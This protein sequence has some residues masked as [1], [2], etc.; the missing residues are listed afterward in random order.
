MYTPRFTVNVGGGRLQRGVLELCRDQVCG[1][2]R[3]DDWWICRDT[4]SIPAAHRHRSGGYHIPKSA[5]LWWTSWSLRKSAAGGGGLPIGYAS[6]LHAVP[7][8]HHT[9]PPP[10]EARFSSPFSIS[11]AV[12]PSCEH[13]RVGS[14]GGVA[15]A[16]QGSS[17]RWAQNC[18]VLPPRVHL[19]AP[20]GS[21]HARKRQAQNVKAPPPPPP[22]PS[23]HTHI[24]TAATRDG[25]HEHPGCRCL[26][27][28]QVLST[29]DRQLLILPILQITNRYAAAERD[30]PN[31][32]R[33]QAEIQS[34]PQVPA[35]RF[36]S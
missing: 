20:M 4:T 30:S 2:V 29:P 18:S 6:H 14:P 27:I 8:Q 16:L 9:A 1:H 12:F 10:N 21:S 23:L 36:S 19:S 15:L 31:G 35:G 22:P 17:N 34:K 7:S 13:W 26:S 11:V 3:L 25:I 32:K 28:N 33:L 24:A 5:I